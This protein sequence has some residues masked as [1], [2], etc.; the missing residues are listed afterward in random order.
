MQLRVMQI[1]TQNDR[2]G[3]M[4][5][6]VRMI[7]GAIH[8]T[9]EEQMLLLEVLFRQNYA[10]EVLAAEITDIETGMKKVGS[11]EYK[12]MITLFERLK[13]EEYPGC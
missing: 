11:D 13:G 9:R 5:G 2:A 10:S 8:L 6:G 7:N 12:Q 1:V 3:V 4:E